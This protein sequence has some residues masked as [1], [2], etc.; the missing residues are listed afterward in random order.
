[1][2]EGALRVS[3][4]LEISDGLVC[5]EP[6]PWANSMVNVPGATRRLCHAGR[7]IR[8]VRA[9]LLLPNLCCSLLLEQ[10][11]PGSRR[12]RGGVQ[13]A[14]WDRRPIESALHAAGF[15]V[16]LVTTRVTLGGDGSTLRR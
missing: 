13:F 2:R 3:G 5:F 16:E 12:R 14:L 7:H 4:R 15:E 6:E 8:L 11:L 1:M 10:S 9:R